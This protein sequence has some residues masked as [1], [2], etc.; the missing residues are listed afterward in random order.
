MSI[1]RRYPTK[2]STILVLHGVLD[3]DNAAE[4]R[5]AISDAVGRQP[6]PERIIVD[7]SGVSEVDHAGIGTLVVGNRLCREIGIHLAVRNP[8]P[9]IRCLL[10]PDD[11]SAPVGD[12]Q[13]TA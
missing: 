4:L 7:L 10:G 2:R 3:Y 13:I 11:V 6:V 9:L 8:A 5:A 1:D 12:R